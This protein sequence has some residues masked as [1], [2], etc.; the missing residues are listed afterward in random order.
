MIYDGHVH[1]PFCPHGT[2]DSMYAYCEMA[3]KHNL[4]GI[5]FA[6][7]APLPPTFV[8]PT[9][10]QDSAMSLSQLPAYFNQIEEMKK[11][12]KGYL[13]ISTGLEVD[14][15]EGFELETKKFLNEYGP[16][17][18][19]S[20]LSV[21]FLKIND[22]YICIDYSPEVFAQAAIQ[23]KSV[24]N[25]HHLYYQTVHSSIKADLGAHKPKRI[26][27]MTLAR[28]FHKKFPVTESFSE[29]TNSIL[30]DII[31]KGYELDY[32]GAGSIK[33]LCREPYP[34]KQVLNKAIE[35]NIPLVYGSDAHQVKELLN[36]FEQLNKEARLKQPSRLDELGR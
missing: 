11:E 32:N 23:L 25:V 18:D 35:L 8:D 7:H 33:P 3:V 27:H 30:L 17:L 6:E 20:I 21:H 36:G 4:K 19:D 1:T 10:N 24:E 15:I 12:F 2:S 14:Y 34:T 26:G 29:I 31:K 28:K 9:P 22:D 13:I 5:T 16:L